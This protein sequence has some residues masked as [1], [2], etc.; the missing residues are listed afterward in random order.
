MQKGAQ[1]DLGLANRPLAGEQSRGGGSGPDSGGRARRRRGPR[2]VEGRG[3]RGGP[4]GACG[5]G[6]GGRRRAGHGALLQ[7]A[8]PLLRRPWTTG[9]LAV[10]L[11]GGERKLAR[12][13]VW[14]EK[15]WRRELSGG[16]GDGSG[17][18]AVLGE[19]G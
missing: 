1:K 15:G 16:H 13:S 3:D 10:E 7:A 6:W 19:R 5:W 2:G 4:M 9:D 12:G 11:H 14:K 18:L 8:A 17:A